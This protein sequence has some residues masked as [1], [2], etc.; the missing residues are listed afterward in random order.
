MTINL[1][2]PNFAIAVGDLDITEMVE[3]FSFRQSAIS[4]ENPIVWEGS[5]AIRKTRFW[6]GES[7]DDWANPTRW[8]RG[9]HPVT[10]TIAGSLFATLRIQS[11]TYDEDLDSAEIS[12]T[13]LLSLLDYKT[14]P[15]DYK[16]IS[17]SNYGITPLAIVA[18]LLS[19]AGVPSISLGTSLNISRIP[20][21]DRTNKSY[22]KLAQKVL[23]ERGYWLYHDADETV[24][25]KLLSFVAARS[26]E[27]YRAQL[28]EYKR[29]SQ[30]N[31]LPNIYRV[32]GGGEKYQGQCGLAST[33]NRTE[34]IYGDSKTQTGY[35][36]NDVFVPVRTTY[37]RKVVEKI[38]TE[39]I[40]E[41]A[42]LI[43]IKTTSFKDLSLV[44]DKGK[45]YKFHSVMFSETIDSSYF[46][47][48][49]RL[50]KQTKVT[51][52]RA[53]GRFP[54]TK[55]DLYPH[56]LAFITNLDEVITLYSHN[57]NADSSGFSRRNY[58]TN[59]LRFKS[60][61]INQRFLDVSSN[62]SGEKTYQFFV[63][64]KE[65]TVETWVENCF[66][67]D[68]PT[69][70]YRRK[71]FSRDP[72]YNYAKIIP[73][74]IRTT[75][76]FLTNELSDQKESATPPSWST[77]SALFPRVNA[78]LNATVKRNYPGA[79]DDLIDQREF[80]YSAESINSVTEAYYLADI[81]A[82]LSV[83]R[84]FGHEIVLSL[85][86][87]P[88]SPDPLQVAWIHN[89]EFLLDSPSVVFDGKEA[90]IAWEGVTIQVLDPP[91]PSPPS[92]AVPV[93]PPA[94]PVGFVRGETISRYSFGGVLVF[95]DDTFNATEPPDF[96][97][98]SVDGNG[99]AITSGGFVQASLN[100]NQFSQILV[101]NV[102]SIVVSADGFVVTTADD[103]Y[104]PTIWDSIATIDGEV[105][106]TN[107][108]VVFF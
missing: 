15:E 5:I 68:D 29:L 96:T 66:N 13:Q 50:T 108:E 53:Y 46:D 24:K 90:E 106:T 45:E 60:E 35:Y 73:S 11:Y 65:K 28:V 38:V 99:D 54:E 58:D 62:A 72:V 52:A 79:D 76:L 94:V 84:S 61:T 19:A 27:R 77:R 1:T 3:Q 18:S 44:D 69:Y 39:L 51:D 23:G 8:A 17:K 21:P 55:Y 9:K 14:P 103:I 81:F 93:P 47:N 98:I 64:S 12:V 74:V 2:P 80:E 83:G 56:A 20:A 67:D 40:Q 107:G 82:D 34:L 33:I 7:L 31:S 32:V 26:L 41:T 6:T 4:I 57:P 22:I 49:G 86:E 42:N 89:R 85:R 95:S 48:Q 16:S 25:I 105:V 10:I 63:A 70:G 97:L 92:L 87:T 30:R 59:V 37:G 43:S 101:D 71:V 88:I 78:K 104:D 36:Y 75:E 91:V 102:G 100:Q